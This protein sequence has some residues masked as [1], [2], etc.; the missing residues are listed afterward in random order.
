MGLYLEPHN[1]YR[2]KMKAR[3]KLQYER[4]GIS[5]IVFFLLS[6]LDKCAAVAVFGHFFG[7]VAKDVKMQTITRSVRT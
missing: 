6:S 7:S 3:T 4:T 1:S 2:N 5:D